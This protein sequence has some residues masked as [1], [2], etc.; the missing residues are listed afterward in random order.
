MGTHKNRGT[1]L[2]KRVSNQATPPPKKKKTK[3]KQNKT[4]T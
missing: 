3:Q 2:A 1:L 4:K